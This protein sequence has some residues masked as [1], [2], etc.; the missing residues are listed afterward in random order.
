MPRTGKLIRTE[1]KLAFLKG[2]GGRW[3]KWNVTVNVYG[4]SFGDDEN[5]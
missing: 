4:F 2:L 5:V 3:R 1:S